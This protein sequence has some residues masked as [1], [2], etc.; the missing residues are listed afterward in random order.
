MSINKTPDDSLITFTLEQMNAR[1]AERIGAEKH[2]GTTDVT[3]LRSGLL[4]MGN[5]HDSIPAGCSWTPVCHRLIK[6]RG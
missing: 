3:N 1:L 2:A 6:P 4:Y 5:V